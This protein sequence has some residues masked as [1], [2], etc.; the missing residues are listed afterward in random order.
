MR[1]KAGQRRENCG[2]DDRFKI[3]KWPTEN[4]VVNRYIMHSRVYREQY[5]RRSDLTCPLPAPTGNQAHG[6]SPN[7]PF[8]NSAVRF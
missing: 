6:I 5:G 4:I 2:S 3:M 1:S 8:E 7:S